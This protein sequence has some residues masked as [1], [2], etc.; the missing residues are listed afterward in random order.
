M[1]LI[2]EFDLCSDTNTK[3]GQSSVFSKKSLKNDFNNVFR[4][5]NESSS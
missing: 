4:G 5:E 1:I 3:S 2:G